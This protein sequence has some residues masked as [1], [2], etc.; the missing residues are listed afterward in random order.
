MNG[1][2]QNEKIDWEQGIKQIDLIYAINDSGSGHVTNYPELKDLTTPTRVRL[3]MVQVSAGS[4]FDPSIITGGSG[5]TGG[6]GGAAAGGGGAGG[7]GG[8]F[9]LGGSGNGGAASGGGVNGGYGGLLNGGTGGSGG[10]SAGTAPSA[11]GTSPSVAGGSGAGGSG[12]SAP[13]PNVDTSSDS[14]CSLS[15]AQPAYQRYSGGLAIL[16][17]LGLFRRTR[18][19]LRR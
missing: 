10:A 13:A 9:G 19:L 11:A 5:G 14:G 6:A 4:T 8:A 17:A 15:N 16:A 12:S 1:F 7:L 18:R 2:W 3:T